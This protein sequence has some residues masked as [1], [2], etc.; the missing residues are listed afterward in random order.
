M[1]ALYGVG[2]V[3]L[4]LLVGAVVEPV[5]VVGF[6]HPLELQLDRAPPQPGAGARAL[7]D[8]EQ[9][10]VGD[11]LHAHEG[12]PRRSASTLRA[13]PI[14]HLQ[15]AWLAGLAMRGA[16]RPGMAGKFGS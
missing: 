4:L 12:T 5:A 1:Q 9:I 15:I 6:A 16:L 10:L 11:H 14:C 3:L 7:L 2:I 13:M 8:V